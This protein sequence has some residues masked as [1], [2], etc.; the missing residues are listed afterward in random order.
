MQFSIRRPKLP[1]S[2]THPEESMYKRL[3]V[4][5]WLNHLNELGQ[6]EEEYKLRKAIFFG[7]IDVSIRGE[8]WP[9]L[10]RYYSHESTSEERE[11]LRLQK[12][13]EYSDIQRRRSRA[14]QGEGLRRRECRV[15]LGVRSPRAGVS[16]PGGW[17]WVKLLA[18]AQL[19]SRTL[20]WGQGL[21][22]HWAATFS[23]LRDTGACEAELILGRALDARHPSAVSGR[24]CSRQQ[25]PSS[26]PGNGVGREGGFPECPHVMPPG[27]TC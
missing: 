12:R 7:G 8:V 9:F 17:D 23:S 25:R 15:P 18:C 4:S 13:K 24:V 1:S 14:S 2:E 10:L 21:I 11:A 27:A 6:V 20:V 22:I 19:P 26:H 3:D 5:A 16:S